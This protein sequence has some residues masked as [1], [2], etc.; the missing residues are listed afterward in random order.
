MLEFFRMKTVTASKE[1]HCAQCTG[2]I[3]V[4]EKH[5]YAATKCDGD[6]YAYREHFEC[7][8]AWQKLN[9][10]LRGCGYDD[11]VPFLCGDE[12][13]PEDIDWLADEFPVV[14]RR[15]FCNWPEEVRRQ[16]VREL[17]HD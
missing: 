10:D 1:H 17:A 6:F 9:F 5:Y 3:E 11:E 4:G 7:R 2:T 16:R 12:W 13:M 15:V 8:Q 14:F